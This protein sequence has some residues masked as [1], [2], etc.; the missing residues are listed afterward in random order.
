MINFNDAPQVVRDF[1]NYMETIKGKSQNT[2]KEYFYDLRTFLRFLKIQKGCIDNNIPFDEISIDD[3]TIDLIKEIDLSDLYEYMAY[4]NRK[5]S[6][7]ANSRA[8]KVA[9][10]KSFFNYLNTKA[11][12]IDVNPAKDLDS[13]K[14]KKGI[15][16]YLSLDES[17]QLLHSV[18]GK[19][20]ARD[21]A[22][23]TLFLNCGLR[24]SE[25]VSINLNN[26]KGD[27]LTVI[28]KGNKE[29]TIYLNQACMNAIDN[30]RRVRPVN[31]VKDKNALFL[32]ERKQRISNKTVQFIVKKY[33]KKAG[34]DSEKFSTHKLRHT[35]ATLM[36]KHGSV[37]I[38]T[39]QEILGHEHL[40]TTEI[41]THVD[42]Q[43]LRNA[44]E[45][46]PLANVNKED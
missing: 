13:P 30:Y 24:L 33:I 34:L 28:G 14:L 19:H 22:I 40:S 10:I 18:E 4:V 35:A 37:D 8:R 17:K 3:V 11:K 12:L 1:L 46:N 25:L 36:Y 43:Q 6:N 44:T 38:R 15:P 21:Y 2:I 7:N 27:T 42:N 29:R 31:G 45:R 5:R 32:S 26:I 16:K 23:L 41:Y 20:Q 39:L 9:S